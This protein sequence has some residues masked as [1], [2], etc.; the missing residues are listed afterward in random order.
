[1]IARLSGGD[2]VAIEA[3]YHYNCLSAYKNQHRSFLRIQKS[4]DNEKADEKPQLARAF[5]ELVSYI[6]SNVENGSYIFK[7]TALHSL[8]ED[9]LH[10]LGVEKS[11]NKSRLKKQ[12]LDHFSGECQE[13]SDGK[14]ILLVFNEGMKRL[15]KESMTYHDYESEAILMLK[16][17]IK[18][19]RQEI[20]DWEP[21]QFSGNFPP[22]YT[23]L[24]P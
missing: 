5:A 24:L 3:K 18:V 9:R 20:F 8:F 6:E 11:I 2:L 13:Q 15:L 19:I 17:V 1:M 16:L 4:Y 12:V 21:F 23:C 14:N 7:L 10:T 22:T